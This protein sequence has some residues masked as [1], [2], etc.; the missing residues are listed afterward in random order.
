MTC[1]F[2]QCICSKALDLIGIR[3]FCCVHGWEHTVTHDA[4]QDSFSSIAKDVKFHVLHEQ[5]R[6]LIITM[7]NG[8]CVY[9]RWY[10]HFG[11]HNH[12]WNDL[13]ESCFVSRF[14]PRNGC[15]DYNLNKGCVISQPTP[16][17]W[18]HPFSNRD[19]WMFT[20]IG[21][22]LSS[23]MCQ[24]GMFNKGLWRSSSFDYTFIL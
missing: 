4:I 24:H 3:L 14:F 18:F 17:G 6:S 19:I 1:G 2:I 21:G 11:K 23:L 20:P 7:T 13:C 16:W 12:Y 5:T 22:L 10:S 9:N 8:Y 15:N